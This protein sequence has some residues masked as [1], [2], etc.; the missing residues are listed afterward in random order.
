MNGE[1]TDLVG[2]DADVF[3]ER[4]RRADVAAGDARLTRCT[5]RQLAF[6]EYQRQQREQRVTASMH[7]F[8]TV[9]STDYNYP[10]HKTSLLPTISGIVSHASFTVLN[11]EADKLIFKSHTRWVN[12]HG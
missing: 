2:E 7:T 5:R 9:L 12:R 1:R 3:V 11:R 8:T 10:P 4:L 6:L